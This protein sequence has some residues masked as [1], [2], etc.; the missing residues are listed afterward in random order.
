[1]VS[2]LIVENTQSNHESIAAYVTP[3]N[4]AFNAVAAQGLSPVTAAG[5]ASLNEIITLQATIIAYMDDFKLLMLMSLAVIP[6]VLTSACA[7]A[8]PA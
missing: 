2:A 8:A 6:R 5:R 4:H 1:I 7:E 3:F